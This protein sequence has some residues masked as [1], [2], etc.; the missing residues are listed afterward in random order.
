MSIEI[1]VF[2]ILVS[3]IQILDLAQIGV[4]PTP[5]IINYIFFLSFRARMHVI[6]PQS[7]AQLFHIILSSEDGMSAH[8][9]E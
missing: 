5:L 4:S 9:R 2:G 8:V 6:A 3:R 1:A 7:S